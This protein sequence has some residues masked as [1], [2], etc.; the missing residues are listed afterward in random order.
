M[1]Y[2]AN[3]TNLYI[4][5]KKNRYAAILCVYNSYNVQSNE[6]DDVPV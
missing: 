3:R 5:F 4:K 1:Y 2:G 6:D